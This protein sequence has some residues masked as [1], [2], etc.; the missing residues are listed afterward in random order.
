MINRGLCR[1]TLK[2]ESS[3]HSIMTEFEQPYPSLQENWP[4]LSSEYNVF[5]SLS[6]DSF[7]GSCNFVFK[8]SCNIPQVGCTLQ[9]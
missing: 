1:L 3:Y 6:L 9:C 8:E 4:G 2:Y 7:L 5:Y